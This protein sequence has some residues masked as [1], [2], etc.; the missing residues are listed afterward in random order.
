M[1]LENIIIGYSGHSY[2]IIDILNSN[3]QQVKYYCDREK[4][5]YNPF[6]LNYLG[7]EED[8]RVLNN[9]IKSNVYISI[10]DNL[11]RKKIFT[12]LEEKNTSLP[13][14]KHF[15][16]IISLNA[17]IGKGTVIMQGSIINAFAIIGKGVI[18]NTNSII[19]HESIIGDFN[20]IAPGAVL[21]GKVKTG[22]NVFIGANAVIKNGISVGDNVII[23]A[24]A[25]VVK[26][27]P[28]N[29]IVIGNPA[30]KMV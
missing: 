16:S 4:K 25:V 5:D 15:S 1:I 22:S 30:H 2:V 20:H 23:G 27:I 21:A 11:S 26:D 29:S 19:E 24:G 10:G 14:L 17:E 7:S 13:I 3:N 6:K 8:P 9:I 12:I 18:C 28:N